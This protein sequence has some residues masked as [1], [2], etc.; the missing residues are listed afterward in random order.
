[1][2]AVC[3]KAANVLQETTSQRKV[4]HGRTFQVKVIHHPSKINQGKADAE[5]A[6]LAGLLKWSVEHKHALLK[7][8]HPSNYGLQ[9]SHV[10]ALQHS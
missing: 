1:V 10:S 6:R 5:F 3:A 4:C 8:R 2:K 9:S 7:E